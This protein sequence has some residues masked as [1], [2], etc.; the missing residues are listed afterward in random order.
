MLTE[1][2]VYCDGCSQRGLLDSDTPLY[3]E[4]F[5]ELDEKY[6]TDCDFAYRIAKAVEKGSYLGRYPHKWLLL[7]RFIRDK[8][9]HII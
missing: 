1:Q 5:E 4:H 2:D 6:L 8:E 3:C 7:Y 9:N